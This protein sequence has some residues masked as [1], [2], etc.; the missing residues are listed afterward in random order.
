MAAKSCC[1]Y[2]MNYTSCKIE[3]TDV[4][5]IFYGKLF[6]VIPILYDKIPFKTRVTFFQYY[7]AAKIETRKS[8]SD[9]T[10]IRLDLCKF[11]V[12]WQLDP[13]FL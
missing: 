11:D 1:Q 9:P 5:L 12:T 13:I 6:Y 7:M 3:V 2:Y 10:Y 8:R 4:T